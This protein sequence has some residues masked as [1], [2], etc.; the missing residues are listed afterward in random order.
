M[1]KGK[2]HELEEPSVQGGA[3]E[4]QSLHFGTHDCGVQKPARC[5]VMQ[6][7]LLTF[8]RMFLELKVMWNQVT[9]THV[10]LA[11]SHIPLPTLCTSA[12]WIE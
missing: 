7:E 9:E 4:E 6:L 8:P 1:I 3:V 10:L 2:A 12:Y 11:S 5:W